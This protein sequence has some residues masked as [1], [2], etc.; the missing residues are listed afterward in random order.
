M[1]GQ[2]I[3]DACLRKAV[4]ER[5]KLHR[6]IDRARQ[7]SVRVGGDPDEAE[8]KLVDAWKAFDPVEYRDLMWANVRRFD[9]LLTRRKPSV[10][11]KFGRLYGAHNSLPG[12]LRK[13]LVIEHRDGELEPL[14]EVDL[15]CCF[16]SMLAGISGR[17]RFRKAVV[18]KDFYE[19]LGRFAE[20]KHGYEFSDLKTLKGDI[21]RDV[22]FNHGRNGFGSSPLFKAFR[23]AFPD[24][25]RLIMNLRKGR[26]FGAS[27][28][29]QLLA[30]M[31]GA[32][33]VDRVI[34]FLDKLG[35]PV[36]NNH[37][38]V[39]VPAT[40]AERV[41]RIVEQIAGSYLGFRPRVGIKPCVPEP[42][43]ELDSSFHRGKIGPGDRTTN[44]PGP[45]D[46]AAQP[47]TAGGTLFDR[48][49]FLTTEAI[50]RDRQA[51]VEAEEQRIREIEHQKW[52]DEM[53]RLS[54][55][56]PVTA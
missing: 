3:D 22:L 40:E 18:R 44:T 37:D 13:Y 38:A 31:E 56:I 28:L 24:E 48:D 10:F 41:Q 52:M 39:L 11:R 7:R 51:A 35:I 4:R 45:T 17:K 16:L 25:A 19:R 6:C 23:D 55:R 2:E 5:E 33:M 30:S 26:A 34:P 46:G 20:R 54:G 49:D 15:G 47:V 36:I 12:F 53:G 42:L 8:S 1:I 43:S 14:A 29:Y 32:L 27:M 9:A 50:E 21:Q